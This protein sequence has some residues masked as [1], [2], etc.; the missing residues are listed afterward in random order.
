[1]SYYL[2]FLLLYTKLLTMKSPFLLLI[3]IVTLIFAGCNNRKKSMCSVLER[4]G[5]EVESNPALA[6]SLLDSIVLPESYPVEEFARWCLLYSRAVDKCFKAHD[7]DSLIRFAV[8]YYRKG[9]D[10]V[11]LAESLYTFGRVRKELGNVDGAA[12]AFLEAFDVSKQLNYDFIAYKASS[13]LGNIY[14][15]QYMYDSA[16][17]LL[18]ESLDAAYRLNDSLYISYALCYQARLYAAQHKYPAAIDIYHKVIS[19]VSDYNKAKQLALHELIG[20]YI[21]ADEHAAAYKCLTDFAGNVFNANKVDSTGVFLSLGTMYDKLGNDKLAGHYLQ[22]ASRSENLYTR[23][24]ANLNLYRQCK[25]LGNYQEAV[26]YNERYWI[27][28]DSIAKLENSKALMEVNAKYNNKKIQAEKQAAVIIADERKMQVYL[29]LMCLFAVSAGLLCFLLRQK[30][31]LLDIRTRFDALSRILDNNR[32]IMAENSAEL[33]RVQ[34]MTKQKAFEFECLKREKQ[35]LEKTNSHNNELLDELSLKLASKQKDIDSLKMES[36]E[37]YNQN[38]LI[39]AT[40]ERLKRRIQDQLIE[41]QKRGESITVY[42]KLAERRTNCPNILLRLKQT[43]QIQDCEWDELYAMVDALHNNFTVRLSESHPG[44]TD[45]DLKLCCLIKLG[46]KTLDLECIL[47]LE[48]D[49]LYKGKKRLRNR[50]DKNRKW[51]KGE[52]ETYITEF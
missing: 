47:N 30:H 6:Y 34:Q 36:E 35:D 16:D 28:S 29:S 2:S 43:K 12:T 39:S 32:V 5:R 3:V 48:E 4:A 51:N 33:E 22:L 46:Y 24:A 49:S 27:C 26:Q 8:D 20:T 14:L 45:K 7:S 11:R 23:C 18:R 15:Y 13:Q 50:L 31:R 44:L 17:S 19:L 41:L 9:N 21:L 37:F 52:L 40:N 42:E 25:R 38:K 1:M 10:S